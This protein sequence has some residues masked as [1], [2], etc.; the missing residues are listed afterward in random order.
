MVEEAT[1]PPAPAKRVRKKAT[2]AVSVT[3]DDFLTELEA[4]LKRA[5]EAGVSRERLLA[6]ASVHRGIGLAERMADVFLD[7]LEGKARKK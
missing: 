2:V 5:L 1:A 4:L 6:R 3:E 7:A